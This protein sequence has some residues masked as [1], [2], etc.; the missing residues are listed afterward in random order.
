MG[1]FEDYE[2][3]AVPRRNKNGL[4]LTP[5]GRP[6]IKKNEVNEKCTTKY[7]SAANKETI[8]GKLL[9]IGQ[10]CALIGTVM[11][12][13]GDI[14]LET[15]GHAD[16]LR[17][18]RS[19]AYYCRDEADLEDILDAKPTALQLYLKGL[20]HLGCLPGA[21]LRTFGCSPKSL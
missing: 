21:E 20:D 3:D 15:S 19:A 17:I 18:F 2:D 6:S 4:E 12:G 9:P 13:P 10:S 7:I 1:G 5:S 11:L 14:P 8:L 16:R